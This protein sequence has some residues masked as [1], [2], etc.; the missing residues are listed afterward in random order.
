MAVAWPLQVFNVWIARL[1]LD[2]S[3]VTEPVMSE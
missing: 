3:K 2:A 1:H